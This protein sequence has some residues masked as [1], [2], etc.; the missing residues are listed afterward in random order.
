MQKL[1]LIHCPVANKTS[2]V[3]CGPLRRLVTY[4]NRGNDTENLKN[5]IV[6]AFR[7]PTGLLL[8]HI[9]VLQ[10][11]SELWDEYIDVTD[12]S[13]DIPDGS[14]V[15]VVTYGVSVFFFSFYP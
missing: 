6:Q 13:A 11:K 10:V 15:K 5:A 1:L 14:K 9:A 4:S 12:A 8:D 7:E 2:L 3:E